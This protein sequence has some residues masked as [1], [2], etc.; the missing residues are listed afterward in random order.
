MA[1][2]LSIA[3]LPLLIHAIGESF[4]AL[5]FITSPQKQLPGADE[6]ATL[7]LHNYGGLLLSTS[8]MCGLLFLEPGFDD[9]AR[10]VTACLGTFHVWPLMRAWTRLRKELGVKG[11]QGRVLG[12][13]LV[14]LGL[15]GG[16][17][18]SLLGMAFC[19]PVQVGK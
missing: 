17:L 10:L 19:V 18:I 12:G 7:I 6:Q 14:H 2:S 5:S 9:T 16:L 13:P 1:S 15:H 4:A 3:K 8:L 11:E